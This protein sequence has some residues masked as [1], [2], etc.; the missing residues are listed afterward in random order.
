MLADK[1][2]Y[3]NETAQTIFELSADYF[4][5]KRCH[6]REEYYQDLRSYERAITER[7][8]TISDYEKALAESK[9][10]LAEKDAEGKRLLKEIERLKREK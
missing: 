8:N 1:N 2:A 3:L 6:D 5:R 9:R 4:I 7:D 10:F